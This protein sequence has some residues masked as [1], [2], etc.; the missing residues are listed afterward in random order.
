MLARQR[1]DAGT[2]GR[3]ENS[4]VVKGISLSRKNHNI[5]SFIKEKTPRPCVPASPRYPVRF[6]G[7]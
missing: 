2:L 1:G 3:G 5:Y 7:C 4:K 6:A